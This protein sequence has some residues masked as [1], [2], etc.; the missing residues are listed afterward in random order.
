MERHPLDPIALVAGLVTLTAGAIA[1]AHQTGV[2]GL[3]PGPVALVALIALGLAGATL[4]MLSGRRADLAPVGTQPSAGAHD[5]GT[6]DEA[7][8]T[9][10]L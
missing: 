3:G 10:A 6:P 9:E 4:V 5:G 2:I 8:G 1:L 7:P